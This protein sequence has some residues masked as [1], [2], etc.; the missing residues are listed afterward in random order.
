L[1][2]FDPDAVAGAEG[3]VAAFSAAKAALLSTLGATKVKGK[4]LTS[5]L[6]F[7]VYSPNS[8]HWCN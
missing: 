4:S 3:L 6:R 1:V 8:E 7:M 2:F 5:V